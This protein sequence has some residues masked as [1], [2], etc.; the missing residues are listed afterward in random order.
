MNRDQ[1]MSSK[2]FY[3]FVKIGIM[4][5]E[6]P[7]IAKN[8]KDK[9]WHKALMTVGTICKKITDE[10][11]ACL[12]AKNLLTVQ[13]RH[14]HTELMLYTTDQLRVNPADNGSSVE[15]RITVDGEDL[16]DLVEFCSYFCLQCPQGDLVKKC[17]M[18]DLLH[19]LGMPVSRTDPK[20]G[21]CEW[22]VDDKNETL[23]PACLDCGNWKERVN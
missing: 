15:K 20:E 2:E 5:G 12:D 13:R 18:R 19:K 16:Y 8:T 17:H 3:D 6:A 23:N 14:H 11:L 22:R 21:Q 10:R 4:A 1:Y 9:E 7:I